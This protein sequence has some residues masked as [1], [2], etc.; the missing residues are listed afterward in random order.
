MNCLYDL[1]LILLLKASLVISLI[2]K[3]YL[4]QYGR[5]DP[6]FSQAFAYHADD[7]PIQRENCLVGLKTTLNP[8][9][10]HVTSDTWQA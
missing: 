10:K 9:R 1:T 7:V 3:R 4:A 2:T 5:Y 6:E 8:L